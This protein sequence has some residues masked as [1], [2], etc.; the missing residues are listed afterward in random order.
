MKNVLVYAML[1][2]AGLTSAYVGATNATP[3]KANTA[4]VTPGEGAPMPT[5]FPGKNCGD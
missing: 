2:V 4:M 3:V 1:L 5:C